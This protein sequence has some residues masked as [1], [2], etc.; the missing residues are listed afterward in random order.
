MPSTWSFATQRWVDVAKQQCATGE[1][2]SMSSKGWCGELW[3]GKGKM[4]RKMAGKSKQI[5]GHRADP[6]NRWNGYQA[7]HSVDSSLKGE[8]FS[9]DVGESATNIRK[10]LF[11]RFKF[12]LSLP[13]DFNS[14]HTGLCFLKPY[15][16][17]GKTQIWRLVPRMIGTDDFSPSRAM[18]LI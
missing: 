6:R 14:L 4:Q 11:F 16:F 3:S 9:L 12:R 8:Q 1:A 5:K 2:V 7:K 13:F 18:I 15:V 10:F 17:E